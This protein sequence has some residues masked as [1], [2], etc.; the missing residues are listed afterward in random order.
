[1]LKIRV[2]VSFSQKGVKKSTAQFF[3]FASFFFINQIRNLSGTDMVKN[4]KRNCDLVNESVEISL[5]TKKKWILI[6][7]HCV[8]LNKKQNLKKYFAYTITKL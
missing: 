3:C 6:R 1:M 2:R 8:S 5:Q 7:K 4:V